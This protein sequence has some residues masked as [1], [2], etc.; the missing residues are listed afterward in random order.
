[1]CDPCP[2]FPIP[3]RRCPP[4]KATRIAALFVVACMSVAVLAAGPLSHAGD[5]RTSVEVPAPAA[6]SDRLLSV[7]GEGVVRLVPDSARVT[8]GVETRADT[9]REAQ[10]QNAAAMN[11]VIDAV[12]RLGVDNK[13]IRTSSINLSAIQNYNEKS[14]PEVVGYRAANT[15]V[16]TC[17]PGTVGQLIDRATA[18]GSNTV[19][20][21][22]FVVSDPEE[23]TQEALKLAVRNARAR[24]DVLAAAAGVRIAGVHSLTA[25][26]GTPP[27]GPY[28]MVF[29]EAAGAG[30]TP[31]MTGESEIRAS[32]DVTYIIN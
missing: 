22:Q 26:G 4:V 15:V 3:F 30:A 28:R 6:Q 25:G 23:A 7:S 8:L 19:S 10:E 20:G 21:I 9:A 24:A 18:A 1:M 14:G 11:A 32:V 2:W 17:K 27:P 16:V 13:D 12:R 29:D 31:I 5:L